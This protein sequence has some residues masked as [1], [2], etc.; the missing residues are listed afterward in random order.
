MDCTAVEE[1]EDLFVSVTKLWLVFICI[2]FGIIFGVCVA[3]I[4]VVCWIK[5]VKKVNVKL[6]ILDHKI[7]DTLI[8]YCFVRGDVKSS[9]AFVVWLFVQ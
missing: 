7:N 4:V 6:F 9:I 8:L 3:V 1:E 5:V 2:I